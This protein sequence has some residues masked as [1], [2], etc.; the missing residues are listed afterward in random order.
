LRITIHA[1]EWG[2]AA[3]VR[4]ALVVDPER[5][6][7]GAA[8]VADPGLCAELTARGLTLDLAPT[9]NWQAGIVGSVAEHPIGEL[10]RMGV[11]V[12]LNTDDLTV[13]DLTL[14]EEYANAAE[15]IGLSLPDLWAIDRHALDVAFID[16]PTRDHL[17][18]EFDLWAANVP[19]LAGPGG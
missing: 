16:E 14:S 4:R 12:T 7:H 9:S 13:S 15:Q 18:A 1:G 5:I 3:Q 8:A 11:P 10:Y 6:A 2:G 19:E 17:R